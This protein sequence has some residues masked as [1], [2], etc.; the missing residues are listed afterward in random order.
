[1]NLSF[2]WMFSAVES[3]M[4]LAPFPAPFSDFTEESRFR[5]VSEGSLEKKTDKE[6]GKTHNESIFPCPIPTHVKNAFSATVRSVYK[7]NFTVLLQTPTTTVCYHSSL[8]PWALPLALPNADDIV[9][10]IAGTVRASWA[11]H[12]CV[13]PSASQT[14]HRPEE[15][16]TPVWEVHSC[17]CRVRPESGSLSSASLKDGKWTSRA[18]CSQPLPLQFQTS[19][20]HFSCSPEM[21]NA[22]ISWCQLINF[23][24]TALYFQ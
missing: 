7:V 19:L 2:E 12:W 18:L 22:R 13:S 11:E 1:M 8:S 3:H 6:E 10:L 24:L 9:F 4:P 16:A 5:V 14:T 17:Y 15:V 20:N 23:R 21:N